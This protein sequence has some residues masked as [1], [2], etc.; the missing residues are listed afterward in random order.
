MSAHPHPPQGWAQGYRKL[1]VSRYADARGVALPGVSG[2]EAARKGQ[3]INQ[4]RCIGAARPYSAKGFLALLC[5]LSVLVF[6]RLALAQVN[7]AYSAF[8]GT[9]W[10]QVEDELDVFVLRAP[11]SWNLQETNPAGKGMAGVGFSLDLPVTFGLYQL[12]FFDDLLDSENF[13]TVSFTPG[14]MAEWAVTERWWLRSYGHLGWG[15]DTQRDEQ[16]W[17]WDAGIKSRYI[18]GKENVPVGLFAELFTAGYNPDNAAANSLSGIGAGVDIRYPVSWTSN[19]GEPLDFIWDLNYRWF[20]NELTF[21]T[22]LESGAGTSTVISDEWR[23]GAAVA[24]RER[25]IKMWFVEL[26][27][28]GL[29]YRIS[30]DGEFRGLTINVSGAFRN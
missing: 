7:W 19:A 10:Y 14:V 22:L 5:L 11:L 30:S 25:R 23:L 15:I 2:L 16:A 21:N 28:I 9:G 29:A 1:S 13:G 26:D 4:Y 20:G 3:N 24:L 12:D 17:I 18:V 6:P 27:Q 8:L